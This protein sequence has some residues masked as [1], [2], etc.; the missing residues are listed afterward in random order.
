[1]RL[2]NTILN[3]SEINVILKRLAYEIVEKNINRL[4][5]LI[6]VGIK[7]RGVPMAKFMSEFVKKTENIDIPVGILDIKFYNDDLSKINDKPKVNKSDLDFAVDNRIL[8][9]IDDV[10]YT[11]KTVQTAIDFLHSKGSPD[12]IQLCVL[13]DRGHHKYPINADF[14]G[15]FVPTDKSEVIKVNFYETDKENSV[16]IMS[17]S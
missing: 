7:S 13:I 16:K 6:F 9:L 12:K 14:V 3:E 1:M 5:N 4:E 2:K 10:L 8:V 15:K 11:G 17:L